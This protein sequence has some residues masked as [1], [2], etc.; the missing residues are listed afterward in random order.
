MLRKGR[1]E[2]CVKQK[3][4]ILTLGLAFW[5]AVWLWLTDLVF[6]CFVLKTELLPMYLFGESSALKLLLDAKLCVP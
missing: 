1:I 4:R 3:V 2:R 6:S 5:L